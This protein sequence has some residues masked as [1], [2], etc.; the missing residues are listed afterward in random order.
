MLPNARRYYAVCFAAKNDSFSRG[1]TNGA[2]ITDFV[3]TDLTSA[4]PN[5]R[6]SW[7]LLLATAVIAFH[8]SLVYVYDRALFHRRRVVLANDF[9]FDDEAR[10]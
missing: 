2:R 5:E 1:K 7:C 10:V 6:A 8:L 3:Y 4:L 9:T